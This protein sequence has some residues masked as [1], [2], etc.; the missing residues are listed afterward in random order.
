[1]D[2][3]DARALE[4]FRALVRIPSTSHLGP[5]N[6]TYAAELLLDETTEGAGA[7][8]WLDALTAIDSRRLRLRS[9]AWL[10][11]EAARFRGDGFHEHLWAERLSVLRAV[12]SEEADLEATR[13]LR[14]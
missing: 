8:V 13:F 5:T 4:F 9:Y 2:D 11:M 6:G 3:R 10:R 12:A 7:E 1:M 14:F